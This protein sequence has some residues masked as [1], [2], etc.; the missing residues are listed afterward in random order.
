M[1]LSSSAALR[2]D[3]RTDFCDVV[4]AI[5][6]TFML[7]KTPQ[8]YDGFA[9]YCQDCVCRFFETKRCAT[10]QLLLVAFGVFCLVDVVFVLIWN[11]MER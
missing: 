11:A 10:V 9:G 6:G 7:H 1:F 5:F 8:Y 2:W 3:Y 4:R